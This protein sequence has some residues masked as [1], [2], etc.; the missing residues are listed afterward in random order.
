[1]GKGRRNEFVFYN[2]E[3]EKPFVDLSAGLALACPK[4]GITGVTWHTLRHTFCLSPPGSGRGCRDG[5]GAAWALHRPGH[6]ALL[7]SESRSEGAG[8]RETRGGL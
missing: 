8:G 4:V 1:M 2:Y 6:H 5:E 3:T 7:A